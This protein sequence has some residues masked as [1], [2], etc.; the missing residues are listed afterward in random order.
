VNKKHP[1]FCSNMC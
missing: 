1:C